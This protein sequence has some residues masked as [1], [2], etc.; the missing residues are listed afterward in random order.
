M[1]LAVAAVIITPV[2]F[3]ALGGFRDAPQ[4]A[5]N[6]VGLPDPWVWTNYT[7]SLTSASFW[8]QL[9]NSAIVAGLST[10]IVVLFA[11]LAAFVIARREFPGR[12]VAYTVFTL[13]LLFPV[14]VA[15]LPLLILVRDI[16]LLDNPLGLALPEA[17]FALP[18]TIII[19]R[20]FFQSIPKELEDAAA[21]DGCGPLGFFFRVLLPLS[22]PVLVT[23]AVLALVSSWNQFLLPLVML[24]DADELDPAPGR[25]QLQHAVHDRHRPHPRVHDARARAG[26]RLLPRRRAPARRRPHGWIGEGMTTTLLPYRDPALPIEARAADLLG[27]MTRAE[28][29]AQLGSFWAFEV[30]G[31]DGLDVDRLAVAGARRDRAHHAARRLHEPAARPRS[32]RRPTRSSASSSRGRGWASRRSSTRSASTG[33]SPG[34]R[35]ASSSRSA[36]RQRSTPTLVTAVAATIRRRMLLTGARHALA[37]VFDI[38]RDPRWGRIEETYGEDP[39]LATELGCA[40][41]EALQGPDLADGVLATA[42]HMVGHGLAEG[43]RNQAPAHLGPRELR[44]E[45]LV[46]FEAAVR[47]AG[48]GSVMPAYCDVDGVPCH[49]SR[50]LL[51]DDPARR[52]GL[53]RDRR[54]G[55]HGRRDARDRAPADGGPRRGCPPGARR[56]RR[57]R[58]AADRG[59]RCAAGR[60]PRRRARRRGA[61]GRGRRTGSCA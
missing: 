21:I 22:K 28:K 49:A 30:V 44:D 32:P 5:A 38:A 33:S 56:R 57:R 16:G 19:L 8:V 7:D 60:G 40:Y 27:R 15:I 4:L 47:H 20:P 52:V 45:Q 6:P 9:R 61:P 35:R 13:G 46:P 23:V 54:L 17:A 41:V 55:L 11:A 58:A 1:L 12:E 43:G 14:T 18:L 53:R 3:A 24:S 36:R 25:D 48:I 37:P 31:E 10:G 26:A 59:V 2:V 34:R 50:E 29:I 51:D 39:Y 42:K